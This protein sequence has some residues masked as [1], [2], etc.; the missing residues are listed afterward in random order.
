DPG[1]RP[2]FFGSEEEGGGGKAATCVSKPEGAGSG[3]LFGS[4]VGRRALLYEFA[5]RVD[6]CAGP[7]SGA[8]RRS[9]LE[10][11]YR[12]PREGTR[13]SEG[14]EGSRGGGHCRRT[15]APT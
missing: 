9:G 11:L 12:R 2:G 8:S 1:V 6:R 10:A 7:P 3:S 14:G 4:R 13:G 15:G 5:E